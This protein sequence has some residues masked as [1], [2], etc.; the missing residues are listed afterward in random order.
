LRLTRPSL[1]EGFVDAPEED[2]T[3]SGFSKMLRTAGVVATSMTPKPL[4]PTLA[5]RAYAI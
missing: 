2:V 4:M 3:S 5:L 1:T